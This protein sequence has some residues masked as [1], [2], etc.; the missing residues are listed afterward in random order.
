MLMSVTVGFQAVVRY[1]TI[2]L[3]ALNAP[4]IKAI[5][6]IVMMVSLV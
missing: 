1:A 4:V 2:L 5:N 3:E 6:S